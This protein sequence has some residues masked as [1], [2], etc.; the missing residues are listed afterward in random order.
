MKKSHIILAAVPVVCALGGFGAGQLLKGGEA[1]A[2]VHQTIAPRTAA[3]GVLHS[4]AGDDMDHGTAEP[5]AHA[6]PDHGEQHSA[7]APEARII[8]A[9]YTQEPQE[10]GHETA[11]SAPADDLAMMHRLDPHKLAQHAHHVMLE[12]T[13]A[14]RKKALDAKMA[15]IEAS[16]DKSTSNP[17][18]LPVDVE[19][20]ITE[21]AIK[22]IAASEDHVVKLGRITLPV[23]SAAKTTYYVADFGVAVT[24]MDQASYYYEGQ[25]A[26]RLRDQVMFTLHELAPTQLMRSDRVNSDVLAERVSKDLREKFAGVENFLFLSLYKTD[27]P[28]S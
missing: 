21:D 8:P 9:S 18:L 14:E 3:E 12:K 5:A 25:N 10:A 22:R 2:P 23:E 13:K 7:L 11:A 24:D 1:A 6:A 26:A 17:A 20:K 15:K 4:L 16:V 27:V 19:A 28:R